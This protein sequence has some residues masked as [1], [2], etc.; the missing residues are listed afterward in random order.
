MA[1]ED[2]IGITVNG[3]NVA[4]FSIPAI[5]HKVKLD[6]YQFTHVGGVHEVSVALVKDASGKE[7]SITDKVVALEIMKEESAD[8]SA[9]QISKEDAPTSVEIVPIAEPAKKPRKPREPKVKTPEEI[10]IAFVA[11]VVETPRATEPVVTP[12]PA[13]QVVSSDV[14]TARL[15]Y[16]VK[17]IG[18]YARAKELKK[19]DI[20]VELLKKDALDIVEKDSDQTIRAAIDALKL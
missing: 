15:P 18:F 9:T 16:L 6:E 4:N 7:L 3:E 12:A 14:N 19:E 17:M 1:K 20:T 10:P 11:P 8:F 13:P 5:G 2:V